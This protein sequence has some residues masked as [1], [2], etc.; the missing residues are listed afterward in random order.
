M[1]VGS[2]PAVTWTTGKDISQ[3]GM[4]STCSIIMGRKNKYNGRKE[5]RPDLNRQKSFAKPANYIE[6]NISEYKIVG[7]S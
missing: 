6:T 4:I 2:I 7:V 5:D 3:A 1:E